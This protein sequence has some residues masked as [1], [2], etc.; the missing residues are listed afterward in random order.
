[1]LARLTFF[2]LVLSG[3]T[4]FA[5]CG[6]SSS[7][8]DD[9]DPTPTVEATATAVKDLT[10]Q[11]IVAQMN[12]SVVHIKAT[13]PE[14]TGG[15]SGIVWEDATH[16]LT[17]A[18]V[19]TGAGSIKVIDP[20]DGRQISAKVVAQSPCDDV[21]LLEVERGNFTPAKIGDSGKL[22]A[23]EAVVALGFP[24]TVTDQSSDKLTVTRGIVSKV[25]DTVDGYND[26]IQTDAAINPGNSGGPL[27]NARGEVIGIN[28]L[29]A[30]TKQDQNYAI[31]INEAKFVADKL[32]AGKNLNWIGA[33]IEPNYRGLASELGIK[34]AYTDGLLVTGIDTGSPAQKAGLGYSDLIYTVDDVNVPTVGSFCDVLRSRKAGDKIRIVITRT[35]R[36]GSYEDLYSDVVLE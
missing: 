29:S 30:R 7:D 16:I 11:E 4:V 25:S 36:D 23:G 6:G 2:G 9:D 35:Y 19:V 12:Q 34:L 31:A 1:M 3:M 26:L 20:K 27:V 17:N 10:P 8:D 32:K 28:T 33:R 13:Y 22:A 14:G 24:G 21:A 5:A 18:H 15:G